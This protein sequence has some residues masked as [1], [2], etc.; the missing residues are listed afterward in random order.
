MGDIM[1]NNTYGGD[2]Y[3]SDQ[4]PAQVKTGT[5]SRDIPFSF[6]AAQP[7][8]TPVILRPGEN[9]FGFTFD[10]WTAAVMTAQIS[11]DNGVTWRN[12]T[13]YGQEIYVQP[14]A[15]AN[16]ALPLIWSEIEAWSCWPM[17]RFRSGTSV[18][19]VNQHATLI[20]TGAVHVKSA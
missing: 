6:I 18:A 7:Y 2:Q 13:K 4:Y 5:Q 20:Y 10:N 16:T 17:L 1:T 19:P 14:T 12:V 11:I 9:I 15:G 8:S 3:V